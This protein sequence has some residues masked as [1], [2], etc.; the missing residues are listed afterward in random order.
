MTLESILQGIRIKPATSFRESARAAYNK[1][2]DIVP[3]AWKPTLDNALYALSNL[4]NYGRT[5]MFYGI[6]IETTSVCNRRC[7]YCPNS[8]DALR[9]LRPQK[10]MDAEVFNRIVD[11]LAELKYKGVIALQH[12]GEP[13]MDKGLEERIRQIKEK[14]PGAQVFIYTNGDFLFPSRLDSLVEAGLDKA[15]ITNHNQDGSVS[16]A[17]IQL[18]NYLEKN[19]SK[20]RYATIRH[21]ITEKSNRGG[22]VPVTDGTLKPAPQCTADMYHMYIAVEGDAMLCCNSYLDKENPLGNVREKKL[23][24]IWNSYAGLRRDIRSG[25]YDLAQCRY[26]KGTEEPMP[27]TERIAQYRQKLGRTEPQGENSRGKTR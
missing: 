11:Q 5:D 9:K 20:K 8:N 1:L 23:I 27:A 25:R 15:I 7:S 12:Y 16:E 13:L 18:E 6:A 21:I 19:P 26:C 4:V 22:L 17:L 2:V 3:A 24:D 14:T 10:K